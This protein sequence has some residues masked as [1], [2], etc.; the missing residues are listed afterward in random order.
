MSC[1]VKGCPAPEHGAFNS[2]MDRTTRDADRILGHA[3]DAVHALALIEADLEAVNLA[4]VG[5]LHS[6]DELHRVLAAIR[7]GA[8]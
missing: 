4:T 8:K 3:L 5:D 7:G 1:N 2:T 6:V